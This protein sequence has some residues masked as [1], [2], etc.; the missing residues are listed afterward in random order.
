MN[1]LKFPPLTALRAFAVFS[2]TLNI[3][4]AGAALNVTHAA[5]S[6]QIKTLET[7]LGV[8]LVDRSGK[9]LS[10]TPS[11]EKLA[12]DLSDGFSILKRGID[13][14]VSG[15][16]SDEVT[17]TIS[18]AIAHRWLLPRLP[19]FQKAHPDIKL[20]VDPTSKRIDL[21]PNGPHVAI[22]FQDG[23]R[24]KLVP[25]A[26][27]VTDMIIAA[28]PSILEGRTVEEPAD[29][30]DLPWMVELGTDEVRDWFS[31]HGLE[32]QEPASVMRMPGNL[33]MDAVL[34]GDVVAYTS[35]AFFEKEL[36]SGELIGLFPMPR[37]GT[38]YLQQLP[39][40]V[41]N[42]VKALV[43]WL[44]QQSVHSSIA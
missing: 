8:P 12:R 21:A 19:E 36:A 30:L 16:D 40:P 22:R 38:Y 34:R 31:M 1:W 4:K 44:L 35:R 28:A 3:T 42:A 14:A 29:L 17:L 2:E 5:V 43:K 24:K 15:Y 9:V 37:F 7:H 10:L 27:I 26:I 11:G 18:P 32:G 33:I 6:Q 23:R 25:N 20:L 41:P 39:E 13:A